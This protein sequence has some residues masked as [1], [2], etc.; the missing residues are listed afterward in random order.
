MKNFKIRMF[1]LL[2][3]F[4]VTNFSFAQITAT[5]RQPPPF[6]F[7]AAD[8]WRVNLTNTG[9]PAEIYLK[10]IVTKGAVNL[11][12]ATSSKFTFPTTLTPKLID[13]ASIS[14]IDLKKNSTEIDDAF[15]STGSLPS[16]KYNICI[17]V[18]SSSNS[19]LSQYCADFEVLQTIKGELI[20][21]RDLENIKK[22]S[23]DY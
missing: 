12:E 21:P 6:Q 19:L 3:I 7:R 4:L 13:A 17:Y 9:S 15:K 22:A 18:Y 20:S 16:G 11:V 8:L 5:L 2:I 1:L 10:A 14:P 23:V